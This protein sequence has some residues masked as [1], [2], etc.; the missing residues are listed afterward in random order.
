MVLSLELNKQNNPS[1]QKET[2]GV[3]TAHQLAESDTFRAVIRVRALP[4]TSAIILTAPLFITY[5][6]LY[7]TIVFK[8]IIYCPMTS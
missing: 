3:W 8:Y 7:L 5:I 1:R 6:H 2:E 4:V